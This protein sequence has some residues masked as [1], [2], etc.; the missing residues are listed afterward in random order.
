MRHLKIVVIFICLTFTSWSYACD[1]E[2][3]GNFLQVAEKT[4]LVAL[5]KVTNYLTFKDIY[6]EHMPMS[7]EVEIVAVYKGTETRKK[8]TVWGDNGI[9][10][11]PYLS[12]F[13]TGNYYVIAF[14][15][16]AE[17]SRGLAN[18]GEK[19]SDYSISICG[20]YWL[21]AD[22]RRKTA[23]SPTTTYQTQLKLKALPSALFDKRKI[24]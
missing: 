23:K 13:K 7:M 4:Q 11:R 15:R 16:A 9:L 21:V 14:K 20:E 8:V 22:M 12:T 2:S 19:E 18:E 1:C 24:K 5:I 17:T 3:Q 10:C 6:N